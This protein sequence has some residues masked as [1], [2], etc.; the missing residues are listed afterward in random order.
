MTDNTFHINRSQN[1]K[2]YLEDN[3][4]KEA[5]TNEVSKFSY[6]DT[7]KAEPIQSEIM[8]WPKEGLSQV[9]DCLWTWHSRLEKLG[10]THLAPETILQWR[11]RGLTEAD[12]TDGKFWFLKQIFG[13]HGKGINIISTLEDYSKFI[14]ANSRPPPC[15]FQGPCFSENLADMF[16]LQKCE[17]DTHLI[18]GRKYVL[19]VY[20]LT[21]GNG[22]TYLYSDCLYYSTLFPVKYDNQD[23][24]VG[25]SAKNPV[26][27]LPVKDTSGKT[28]V[29]KEQMR[30]NVHISHWVLDDK[31][32]FDIDDDRLMGLLSDLPEH[33]EIRRNLFK[34]VRQMSRVYNDIL[35][36]HKKCAKKPK[37]TEKFSHD[38]KAYQIWGADYIVLSD[39]SVKCLEINAFPNLTHGDPYKNTNAKGAK[40]RPHELK[41][42]RDGFDEGLMRLFG[43]DLDK[44]GQAPNNWELV[45]GGVLARNEQ[46]TTSKISQENKTQTKEKSKEQSKTKKPKKKP[47]KPK[48]SGKSRRTRRR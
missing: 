24:Y 17:T 10:L 34:N 37:G 46:T 19:R 28:F 27:T 47:R 39:L 33:K 25:N 9:V 23:C 3:G 48:K 45:N 15:K 14:K 18:K 32:D 12:F 7:Y 36:E 1:L 22:E 35:T 31:K 13:V 8:V 44:K 42:R 29:P 5:L 6:Y 4:W 38:K 41:F 30:K 2:A 16:V 20:S 40:T 11:E 43:F 21:M 26:Y